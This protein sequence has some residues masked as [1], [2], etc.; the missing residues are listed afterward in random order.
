MASAAPWKATSLEDLRQ[1]MQQFAT[2][3]DWDQFHTPRNL[4]LALVCLLPRRS[5]R[6]RV[7]AGC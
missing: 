5:R 7:G 4:L 3:R 2:D 6:H 1:Q